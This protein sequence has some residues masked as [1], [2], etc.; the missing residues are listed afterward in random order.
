MFGLPP[1]LPRGSESSLVPLKSGPGSPPVEFKNPRADVPF[2]RKSTIL[3]K[4][5]SLTMTLP[6]LSPDEN[7]DPVSGSEYPPRLDPRELKRIRKKFRLEDTYFLPEDLERH[8]LPPL[9]VVRLVIDYYYTYLQ[10]AHQFLPNRAYFLEKLVLKNDA[11]IVHAM[12]AC[13]CGR[14]QWPFKCEE[15]FWVDKMVHF[16]DNLNDFGM[17]VALSLVSQCSHVKNSFSLSSENGSKIFELV[18]QNR[19]LDS[20]AKLAVTSARKTF[21]REAIIRMIWLYW[22]NNIDFRVRQ[23]RPYSFVFAL[24]NENNLLSSK[25][26]SFSNDKL[27]FPVSNEAFG[28]SRDSRRLTWSDIGQKQYEDYVGLIKAY[29]VLQKMANKINSNE[30]TFENRDR[31]PEFES[32][33]KDRAISLRDDTLL[34]N[35]HFFLANMIMVLVDVVQTST[36]LLEVLAFDAL[37]KLLVNSSTDILPWIREISPNQLL[38]M[39]TLPEKL[40]ALSSDQ[41]ACL[42]S[43]VSSISRIVD[44]IYVNIGYLPWEPDQQRSVHFGVVTLDT[45]RPWVLCDELNT[46]GEDAWAKSSDFAVYCACTA[47]S[48]IPSLAVL[49]KFLTLEVHSDRSTFWL[50]DGPQNTVSEGGNEKLARFFTDSALREAF[51]KVA[52]FVRFRALIQNVKAIQQDTMTNMNKIQHFMEEVLQTIK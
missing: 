16:W 7:T 19:Y 30:L 50:R 8:E 10:P 20:L 46:K 1:P 27:P 33:L 3:R 2:G 44:L 48:V 34:I 28:M 41:W 11:A 47:L 49:T 23:G 13:V 36:L 45:N 22:L 29:L 31:D 42:Y 26:E 15:Q 39:E 14:Q 35:S 38:S 9:D 51:N 25:M 43:L 12:I 18:Y 32:Y 40:R 37:M 5:H 21:E 4:S 6:I 52:V 24:N 17:L